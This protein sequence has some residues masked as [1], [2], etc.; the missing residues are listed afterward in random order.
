MFHKIYDVTKGSNNVQFGHNKAATLL[1]SHSKQ[2]H[3]GFK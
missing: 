2:V 3:T 1:L